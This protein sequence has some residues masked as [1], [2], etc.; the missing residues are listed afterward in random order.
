MPFVPAQPCPWPTPKST[1]AAERAPPGRPG[2]P[3]SSPVVR[4]PRRTGAG[5]PEPPRGRGAR[6]T[7]GGPP[8]PCPSRAGGEAARLPSSARRAGS[9]LFASPS[10]RLG[11][12]PPCPAPPRGDG[13]RARAQGPWPRALRAQPSSRLFIAPRP[14]RA[15]PAGSGCKSGLG[16]RS[17]RPRR[18]SGDQGPGE[19][20]G[21]R[22]PSAPRSPARGGFP[23]S[24]P[25]KAEQRGLRCSGRA[26]RSS[27]PERAR[28]PPA[29]T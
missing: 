27:G 25:G 13:A 14:G 6:V 28:E 9:L 12:P 24:A 18:E 11:P 5:R 15:R 10:P 4:K 22:A 3:W 7:A 26:G 17:S 29:A 21:P 19:A 8:G 16:T 20:H 23:R 1:P 2:C